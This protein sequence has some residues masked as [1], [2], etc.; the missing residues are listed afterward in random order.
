M[1]LAFVLAFEIASAEL[2]PDKTIDPSNAGRD[3]CKHSDTD[4]CKAERQRRCQLAAEGFLAEVSR[5]DRSAPPDSTGRGDKVAEFRQRVED[6]RKRGVA[7]CETW[8]ALMKMA[9]RQ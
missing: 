6:D 3:P 2:P 8:S 4:Y 9:A 1:L 7:P 5:I